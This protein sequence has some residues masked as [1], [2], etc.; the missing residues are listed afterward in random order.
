MMLISIADNTSTWA[1]TQ[2]VR[3]TSDIRASHSDKIG[4]A[5]IS[6]SFSPILW[7]RLLAHT[8]SRLSI[9]V[10]FMLLIYVFVISNYTITLFFVKSFITCFLTVAAYQ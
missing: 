10:C 4:V 1:T 9:V 2:Q 5:G 3:N 6:K 8:R 7:P